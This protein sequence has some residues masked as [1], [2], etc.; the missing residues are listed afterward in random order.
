MSDSSW[1]HAVLREL[2]ASQRG[3]ATLE[4]TSGG[5]AESAWGAEAVAQA[6]PQPAQPMA[7]PAVIQGT[8]QPDVIQGTGQPHVIQGTGQPAVIQGTGQPDVIQGTGQPDVIQGTGQPD[9][10]QGTGPAVIQGTGPVPPVAPPAPPVPQ[11]HAAPIPQ[12]VH[13]PEPQTY[14]PQTYEPQTYEPQPE[15][16]T[17]PAEEALAAPLVNEEFS[18]DA[19][20]SPVLSG[21]APGAPG[22]A[23]EEEPEQGHSSGSYE[24][25]APSSGPAGP[26]AAPAANPQHAA[27]GVPMADEFL[28]RNVHG[29]PLMRRVGRGMRKAVGASGSAGAKTQAEIIE[30]L[31]R[32]VSSYRQL[33]VASVRGGAG[34]TTMAAMLATQLA[35]HRTDRVLAMDADAELGSLPLRLGVRSELSLFDLAAQQPRTFEEAAQ[36]L[37]RTNDGLWVL[38]ST[39]GG[40]IAGEFNLETF[41]SALSSLARYISTAVIDCGAGILTE[42][43]RGI[44]STTH[45]LVLVTPGT[46]DGALSA[47]GALEWFANSGQQA[48]MSRTVIAM[49]MHAPQV[50]ADL[51]RATQ[52]LGA[53]GLPV[54]RV[55]YDRHVAAG[56]ALDLSRIGEATRS[57][58]DRVAYEA[59][60][61][62]LGMPGVA[63]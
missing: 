30:L 56:A 9:V 20:I 48:L 45:G 25:P 43:H 7:A 41:Q 28:R 42:L 33:A 23:P 44:L 52:M 17:E 62:A 38:S 54:V 40:R 60:G 5:T 6:T 39:R 35:R 55:P 32:P 1:Q 4:P 3:L 61:R 36:Y 2:G 63:R 26:H 34:K 18:W 58:V 29:D 59:F 46:V 16:E 15:A 37:M 51:E 50:G 22:V 47:R 49:V 19:A 31:Q 14:E 53:W 12:Q 8:G 24:Q 21:Q 57:A 27:S 11:P 13:A 10:I